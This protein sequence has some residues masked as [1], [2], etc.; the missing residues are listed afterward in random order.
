MVHMSSRLSHASG[1]PPHERARALMRQRERVTLACQA[2][3]LLRF[4]LLTE[5]GSSRRNLH[6]M[7]ISFYVVPRGTPQGLKGASRDADAR[8]LRRLEVR[9]ETELANNPERTG[10]QP[11]LAIER[12]SQ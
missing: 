8:C 2:Q 6:R 12:E 10:T 4:L 3:T 11:R 9:E 7:S 5:H 1:V